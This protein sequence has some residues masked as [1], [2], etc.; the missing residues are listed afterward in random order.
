[1]PKS[2]RTAYIHTTAEL[3]QF[4]QRA[5]QHPVM[6]VDT[7]F[8][9]ERTYFPEL[10][11]VQ[12]ANDEEAV[13]VDVKSKGIKLDK[14]WEILLSPRLI[15]IF[16]ASIEDVSIIKHET[17]EMPLPFFDT[18]LAAMFC[19]DVDNPGYATLVK[20]FLNVTIDK[21]QQKTNWLAR[22]LD[23]RQIDYAL[24]DVTHLLNVYKRIISLLTDLNRL[25]WVQKEHE[26]LLE[27]VKYQG[28]PFERW[29][30]IHLRRSDPLSLAILRE[31][32]AWRELYARKNN[33]PPNWVLGEQTLA[34]IA[35]SQPRTEADLDKIRTIPRGIRSGEPKRAGIWR[36]IQKAL[37]T[38][39][40]K[41]PRANN[42]KPKQPKADPR[43]MELLK[44]V[45]QIRSREHKLAPSTI[46][47][48]STLRA[49]VAGTPEG[50]VLL[51]GWRNEV[52]G[53]IAQKFRQGK[54]SLKHK[55]GKLLVIED[56]G[57]NPTQLTGK[58]KRIFG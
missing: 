12:L 2:P 27:Q 34:E 1:M 40:D 6:A 18:Q 35:M 7:E 30:R 9:S 53:D 46:T 29:Q 3:E 42:H 20:Q 14:L 52:F 19:N 55:N 50:K 33:K 8:V 22:P 36:A 47:N 13:A 45:L 21:S 56:D 23:K 15:K 32:T 49:F 10:C 5:L 26:A 24:S 58:I 11:L 44:L 48:A 17:G 54:A 16:H 43:L 51:Q 37:D 39:P 4:C 28:D 38:P 57:A 41:R 31:I 25:E